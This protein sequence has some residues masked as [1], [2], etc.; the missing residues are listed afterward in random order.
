MHARATGVNKVVL[1]KI[2]SGLHDPSV[3]AADLVETVGRDPSI[4]YALLRILNSAHLSLERKVT[5]LHQALVLLGVDGLRNWTTMMVMSRLASDSQEAFSGALIR[6]KMCELCATNKP[7][8][9]STVA[10]TAGLLSA[11][12]DILGRPLPDVVAELG[13]LQSCAWRYST[14]RGRSGRC[15]DGCSAT[16]PKTGSSSRASGR[17]R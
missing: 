15:W 11:L 4:V 8:A 14:A 7:G 17:R 10:F 2:L 13:S 3:T 5:S 16:R 1:V 6:A 12:P 9:E